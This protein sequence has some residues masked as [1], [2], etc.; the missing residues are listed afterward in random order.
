MES[1]QRLLSLDVLR[2]MTIAGMIL[3]NNP[4]DW[5]AVYPPLLHA[6]WHG[7][8][9]TDLIF[10]FFLFMVGTAIAIALGKRKDRGDAPSAMYQKIGY[11][12][13]VIFGLGV[14]LAAFPHFKYEGGPGL[15]TVHYILLSLAMIAVFSREVL[16]RGAM[17]TPGGQQARRILAY[18]AW[19]AVAGMVIIGISGH[20]HLD[21]LRIPGV[22][23][24]IALVYG[25]A[26]L[27][28][29]HASTRM[30]IFIGAALL[31]V[32][33]ALMTLVPVPGGIAPNLEPETNL[34]AWLDRTVL[35]VNHLWSQSKTWDP[36]GILGTIPAVGTALIG[37]W[38][39]EVLRSQKAPLDKVKWLLI[40]GV[41][42]VAIAQV[43]NLVFPI[44][45]AL[46]T[47]SYVLYA[48]G[49]A[50]LFLGGIYWMIDIKGIKGWSLPFQVYGVNA[51][52]AFILSG[53]VAKLLSAIKWQLDAENTQTL[54]GW[55]YDTL[56]TPY[57]SAI[58][59]SL[60][61]ALLNVT[62][63]FVCSWFLYKNR[64]FIKV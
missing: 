55:I 46:W 59:A 53:I 26:S 44:N 48:G 8:T 20:Y 3:V 36:E 11:R 10:P 30:Q 62:F 60:G 23:Q 27:I 47:S 31:L 33:W 14:F 32:Y 18:T 9:P 5:G 43:W 4:G 12:T 41:L 49:L 7:C 6:K 37:I 34:G 51:L 15:Q 19:I 17:T 63:I 58:N 54:K 29:L 40:S 13:L 50:Q 28:F 45:K 35:G 61:F 2:G 57:F 42:L 24:R 25:I 21:T 64:I 22:L 16:D 38:S 1:Q 39:G 56:F 52:F